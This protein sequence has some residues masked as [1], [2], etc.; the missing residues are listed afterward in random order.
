MPIAARIPSGRFQLQKWMRQRE[1]SDVHAKLDAMQGEG[2]RVCSASYKDLIARVCHM[3]NRPVAMSLLSRMEEEKIL[4]NSAHVAPV[5]KL[6]AFGKLDDVAKIRSALKIMRRAR[7]ETVLSPVLAD[8]ILGLFAR[9]SDAGIEA[10]R[11]HAAA[12]LDEMRK[13]NIGLGPGMVRSLIRLSPSVNSA[14]TYYDKL[15]VKDDKTRTALLAACA[16]HGDSAA[17]AGI[18][19]H[20]DS[21]EEATKA[22]HLLPRALPAS[23]G[24]AE[25]LLVWD[26]VCLFFEPP[27]Q[28]AQPGG[29][30]DAEEA[31]GMS[32][33]G[34]ADENCWALARAGHVAAFL[35]VLLSTQDRGAFTHSLLGLRTPGLTELSHSFELGFG[36]G[37][38]AIDAWWIGIPIEGSSRYRIAMR[39]CVASMCPPAGFRLPVFHS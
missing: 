38:S 12:L 18:L 3:R 37:A 19:E 9:L 28:T 16:S 17:A 14:F 21:N 7:G 8:A 5:V 32:C 23:P 11:H 10:S 13:S 35:S 39:E 20:Y 34:D 6:L 1:F 22:V 31:G 27:E 33:G 4:P 36:K 24:Y 30:E 2:L 15:S 25:A 29:E 26:R